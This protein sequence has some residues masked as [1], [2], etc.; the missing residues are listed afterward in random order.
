MEIELDNTIDVLGLAATTGDLGPATTPQ[1]DSADATD[2]SPPENDAGTAP[3][4]GEAAP[5]TETTEQAPEASFCATFYRGFYGDLQM[6]TAAAAKAHWLKLGQREGRYGNPED[7]MRD[8]AAKGVNLPGDFDPEM[9][10]LLNPE[11]RAR[12]KTELAL[13]AHYIGMR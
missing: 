3:E 9:Y 6:M 1:D 8:F 10:G 12:L 11:V 4:G 5:N 7:V 13:T 2:R